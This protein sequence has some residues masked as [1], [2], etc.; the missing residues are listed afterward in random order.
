[1]ATLK[2]PHGL[3]Q[4]AGFWAVI[5]AGLAVIGLLVYLVSHWGWWRLRHPGTRR[6][7]IRTWHGWVESSV[8]SE[9]RPRNRLRKPL[10]TRTAKTDYSWIFWDPT[11]AKQRR[12]EQEREKTWVRY[13]PRWM[14]SSPFGSADAVTNPN[15][16][17]E[18]ARSSQAQESEGIPIAG[19]VGT[20]S[21]LGRH[22]RRSWRRAGR[23]NHSSDTYV[24]IPDHRSVDESACISTAAEDMLDNFNTI[25]LRKTSRQYRSDWNANSEDVERAM[26]NQ[27]LAPTAAFNL[28]NLFRSPAQK[29]EGPSE[30]GT[31]PSSCEQG[32][33][34]Y[35]TS[36]SDPPPCPSDD[37]R[38][39]RTRSMQCQYR[40]PRTQSRRDLNKT[41]HPNPN[42][43]HVP[44][45]SPKRIPIRPCG[46]KNT[47]PLQPSTISVA[48]GR[49]DRSIA[50]DRSIGRDPDCM[51][52]INVPK[53][54]ES[55]GAWSTDGSVAEAE[56]MSVI[57]VPSI[58][59]V[60]NNSHDR[61]REGKDLDVTD[62]E[63]FGSVPAGSWIVGVR[64]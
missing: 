51:P 37:H 36:H 11:G 64:R 28:A 26:S 3:L 50:D 35:T 43:I 58:L 20:L 21:L 12:F 30:R 49:D 34:G 1:M 4:L 54:R 32:R 19:H 55:K 22:W 39:R 13:L 40:L 27:L 48:E 45:L 17:V 29:T 44:C 2:Y 5:L 57:S 16:D 9:K 41:W 59:F 8:P 31:S 25:R 46:I 7:L 52:R 23:S 38:L 14:R 47:R 18:A 24:E 56:K 15:L 6:P 53:T 60:G 61:I 62:G 42:G 10:V 33:A 63:S